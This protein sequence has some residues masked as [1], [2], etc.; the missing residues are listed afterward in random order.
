M[1]QVSR[2]VEANNPEI[3][4]AN[5]ARNLPRSTPAERIHRAIQMLLQDQFSPASG[6]FYYEFRCY[7]ITDGLQ[8]FSLDVPLT[9]MTGEQKIANTEA[10]HVRIHQ[11][12]SLGLKIPPF[13][14]VIHPLY[15]RWGS[16]RYQTRE[17]ICYDNH[18]G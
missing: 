5:D 16:E 15:Y 1:F 2:S 18:T 11:L 6:S 7:C 9:N 14:A 3:L 13:S 12:E 10:I 8:V 17:G 4:P